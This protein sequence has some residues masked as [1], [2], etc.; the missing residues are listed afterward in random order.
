MIDFSTV[1]QRIRQILVQH[2][3][4]PKIL[5][6]D[7]AEAL[8]LDPQYFAVIK[9]RKKVP[10]EAIAYFCKKHTVNMNWILLKQKPVYLEQ[11]SPLPTP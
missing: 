2:T 11:E 4:K 8:E 5:D 1:I 6:R 3:Q 9:K 7:I 10:Y